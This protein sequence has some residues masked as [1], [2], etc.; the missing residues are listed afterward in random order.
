MLPPSPQIKTW[1]PRD[2]EIE[3]PVFL[4]MRNFSKNINLRRLYFL[5]PKWATLLSFWNSALRQHHSLPCW[6]GWSLAGQKLW[7]PGSHKRAFLR[8][9]SGCTLERDDFLSNFCEPYSSSWEYSFR[10]RW[11]KSR[12]LCILFISERAWECMKPQDKFVCL[13]KGYWGKFTCFLLKQT[14]KHIYA[15]ININI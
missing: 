10:M 4:A 3:L 12:K 8:P 11:K 7:A 14:S 9:G 1:N 5:K 15:Y 6:C 2:S 13:P